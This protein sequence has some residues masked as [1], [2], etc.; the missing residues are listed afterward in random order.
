MGITLVVKYTTLSAIM[1]SIFQPEIMPCVFL[2]QIIILIKVMEGQ[3]F[4][5]RYSYSHSYSALYF[6]VSF[7][8]F[9]DA[10]A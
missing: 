1:T 7:F 2:C 3:F 5:T 6:G 8:Y 9:R 10:I 4:M